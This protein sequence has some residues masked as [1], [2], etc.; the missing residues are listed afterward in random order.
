MIIALLDADLAAL[1]SSGIVFGVL[2]VGITLIETTWAAPDT[3][4][5]ARTTINTCCRVSVT[6]VAALGVSW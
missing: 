5:M 6:Q 2:T 4:V 1:T 3:L